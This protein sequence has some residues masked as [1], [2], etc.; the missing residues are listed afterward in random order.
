MSELNRL[1]YYL[2]FSLIAFLTES[3][4][5]LR[6]DYRWEA[7]QVCAQWT[8]TAAPASDEDAEARVELFA[9]GGST[10]AS[11]AYTIHASIVM[12][13]MGHGSAPVRVVPVL[14]RPGQFVLTRLSFFMRGPWEI[15]LDLVDQNSSTV[16]GRA[17]Q[18]YLA[19][20]PVDLE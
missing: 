17:I 9:M 10:L 20:E 6:C 12:P 13:S 19:Y 7:Q 2:A 4:S 11:H 14:N 18:P 1:R 3:S 5:A 15:R 16:L 8:W